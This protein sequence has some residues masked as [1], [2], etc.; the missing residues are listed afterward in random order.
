MTITPATDSAESVLKALVA[1]GTALSKRA[2]TLITKQGAALYESNAHLKAAQDKLDA[3]AVEATRTS[4]AG[5]GTKTDPPVPLPID[6]PP[7]D[8]CADKIKLAVLAER[9][10]ILDAQ[11][12]V[13]RVP[14]PM[15]WDVMSKWDILL[16]GVTSMI[17]AVQG[18]I[19]QPNQ[20]I[21]IDP[22]AVG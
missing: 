16:W 6:I 21:T 17:Y 15:H 14:H 12:F 7:L 19:Y 2:A 11:K 4:I 5:G 20:T 9:A 18:E 22:V 3:L 8:P 13:K 10:R 1:S